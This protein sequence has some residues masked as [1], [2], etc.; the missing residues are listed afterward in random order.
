MRKDNNNNKNVCIVV[1]LFLILLLNIVIFASP[2]ITASPSVEIISP[3]RHEIIGLGIANTDGNKGISMGVKYKL[4]NFDIPS[5]GVLKVSSNSLSQAGMFLTKYE[6]VKNGILTLHNVQAG[7]HLIHFQL[8]KYEGERKDFGNEVYRTNVIFEIVPSEIK[9]FYLH[10]SS[11]SLTIAEKLKIL[12]P[13]SLSI[14]STGDELKKLVM[15]YK[16]KYGANKKIKIAVV[17]TLTLDGQKT[18][19]IEQFKRMQSSTYKDVFDVTYYCFACSENATGPLLPY[20][21][22]LK[23]PYFRTGV[24]SIPTELYY[25]KD[26]PK[27]LDTLLKNEYDVALE[28]YNSIDGMQYSLDPTVQLFYN[29]FVKNL[30][31]KD[32]LIF[33]NSRDSNDNILITAAKMANV[34]KIVMDLPNLYPNIEKHFEL[35]ACVGPS[36]FVKEHFSVNDLNCPFFV[37]NP[38]VSNFVEN[39]RLRKVDS[40]TGMISATI[41]FIGRMESEKSVGL[42]LYA[43]RYLNHKLKNLGYGRVKVIMIGDGALLPEL[44]KVAFDEINLSDGDDIEFYGWVKREEMTKV[45]DKL[46]IV[47]QTSLRDAETFGISNIEAMGRGV[48]IVHFG[49]GGSLEYTEHMLT[50]YVV[51]V[52]NEGDESGIASIIEALAD[53]MYTMLTNITLYEA[54][55]SNGLKLV[56]THFRMDQMVDKYLKIYLQLLI[57]NDDG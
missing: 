18:I 29:L 19:W 30:I 43:I 9:R 56:K 28:K 54:I 44:K 47:V 6:E 14:D 26:F 16:N 50:G 22:A 27:S 21:T 11:P 5:D 7:T 42:F 36:N 49:Y 46:D 12:P 41:G 3:F 32:I 52:V 39:G 38:G 17:G 33:A 53:G 40:K 25:T 37:I 35:D 57:S 23:I 8:I 2:T 1:Y 31:K 13:P 45:L 55:S 34:K 4:N 51:D 24:F 20:L 15:A 10:E 48:P